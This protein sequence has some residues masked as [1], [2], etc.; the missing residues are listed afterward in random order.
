MIITEIGSLDCF[1]SPDKL[2]AYAGLSPSTYQSE[3]LD[4]TYAHM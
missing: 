2:S 4:A 1:D 3:Q